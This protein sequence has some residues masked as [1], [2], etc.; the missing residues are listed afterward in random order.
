MDV[1]VDVLGW[2]SVAFYIS[3][4]IFN[5][6]KATRFAAFGSAANDIIWAFLMGW[7]AKVILNLSVASINTY[8]YAKDFTTVSHKLIMALGAAMGLGILTIL[9]FAVSSFIA[10]PTLA[11][12]FQF[13]DLG[14]ILAAIYMTS[15]RKYRVLM[16]ISGLVGMVGYYGNPQ[17]MIIKAMVIGIMSYKLITQKEDEP[18]AA[19]A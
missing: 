17:M 1:V 3:L 15:L 13:A 18:V 7:H 14:V 5:S 16:L 2:T 12:A 10:E 4:T 11:V 9:Y 6:M 19:T 8:R